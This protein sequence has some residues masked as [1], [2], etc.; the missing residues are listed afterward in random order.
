MVDTTG[1]RVSKSG[2]N[3]TGIRSESVIQTALE[4]ACRIAQVCEEFR[5]QDTVVL[6]VTHITPLFDYFVITTGRSR[7]QL[8]AIADQSDDVMDQQGSKRRSTAGYETEWICQDYGDVV[9]H[10]FSPA[11]REQ[12]SLEDLWADAIRV[13]WS[14]GKTPESDTSGE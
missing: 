2:G 5:G 14:N 1:T 4:N 8:H 10:V 13:E 3:V 12:Y 7:R 11:A 6:D 9:L